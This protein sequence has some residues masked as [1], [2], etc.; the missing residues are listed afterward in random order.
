MGK[1]EGMVKLVRQGRIHDHQQ[2]DGIGGLITVVGVKYT[3]ARIIAQQ[4]VDLVFEKLERNII[5]CSTHQTPLHGGKIERFDDYLRQAIRTRSEGLPPEIIKHLVYNYGSNYTKILGYLNEKP[6]WGHPVVDSSP[7][8]KAEVLHGVRQ[9]MAQT[10]SDI[11][12]RRTELGS[13]A[14]PSEVSLRI[15]AQ[16]M[17]RELG[18]SKTR[19]SEEIEQVRTVYQFKSLQGHRE[20]QIREVTC[21]P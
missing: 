5:R 20:S 16:L 7:V 21:N 12:L 17:A 14:P 4:T 2:E 11:I 13:A 1:Q 6:E 9:E 15:C 10:L 3:T 19:L 18:W 8:L